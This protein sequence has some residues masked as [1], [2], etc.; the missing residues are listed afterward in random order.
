MESI[1]EKLQLKDIDKSTWKK[2]RFDQIAK[3]ISERVE[4]TTTDLEIYVGLEHIDSESI[5]IKRYGK[6]EDVNG[7]KLRCYPGDIIFGRRRAYQRKAAIVEFD[8][9][10]SAHSLVLRANPDVISSSLFP[11]FLHSDTFM[12]LAV[13]ISVGSLSPTIN[14]GDL[15]KQEFLIPPKDQQEQ[16]AELLWAGDEML[17]NQIKMHNNILTLYE[18]TLTD[19]F[20]Q[21]SEFPLKVLGDLVQIRS[22]DSPSMFNNIEESEGVPF[23]KVKDLNETIKFQNYA[24]E[25]VTA[26]PNKLIPKGSVIFPKRGEAIM[27][28]KVRIVVNDCH[29]DT[30]T[31]ALSV[32]DVSQLNNEFLYYF[33]Y[34]KK[35]Y[36]IADVA[37]IPQINNIHINPYPINLPP[38]EIQVDFVNKLNRVLGILEVVKSNHYTSKDLQKSLINKIF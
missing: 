21:A 2:Y 20:E 11:F 4:P 16:I 3:N 36:K 12:H 31:M 5:H 26:I 14:W 27:T 13:D 10:C 18:R 34:F 24:K 30:N 38:L 35:L 28:N 25:W 19:F 7:T 8:G 15:K 9:F 6:R 37:Q 32:K 33:L 22:G 1:V 17:E 23:L 29:V